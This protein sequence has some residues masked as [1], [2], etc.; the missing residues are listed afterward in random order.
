NSVILGGAHKPNTL[1]KY[2]LVW[3]KKYPSVTDVPKT[4]TYDMMEKVRNW[5]RIKINI[6]F[7][8][9][10]IAVCV[11]MIYSGKK[12][13]ERGETLQ[14]MNIKWHEEQNIKK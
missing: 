2:L 1:E 7:C 5:A 9:V 10:T 8:F 12:A 6:F 3:M 14:K 13:A 11:G 4:V